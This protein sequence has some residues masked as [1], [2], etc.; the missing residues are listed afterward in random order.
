MKEIYLVIIILI[1][2]ILNIVYFIYDIVKFFKKQYYLNISLDEMN[3]HN[4]SYDVFDKIRKFYTIYIVDKHLI[5]IILFI[6]LLVSIIVY[7]Y[8]RGIQNIINDLT[9]QLNTVVKK[10]PQNIFE[11]LM[12]VTFIK[13]YI[14]LS[15]SIIVYIVYF[16]YTICEVIL[17]NNY[18]NIYEYNKNIQELY[19]YLLTDYIIYATDKNNISKTDIQKIKEWGFSGE[20]DIIKLRTGN[21]EDPDDM[22]LKRLKLLV[23]FVFCEYY[24]F[25]RTNSDM[26]NISNLSK[27]NNLNKENL[28][29]NLPSNKENILPS[30]SEIKKR[31]RDVLTIIKGTDTKYS[32]SSDNIVKLDAKYNEI[33]IKIFE[34]IKNIK[35]Y[36]SSKKIN[37]I[38]IISEFIM[39]II[40]TIFAII[41]VFYIIHLLTKSVSIEIDN[42]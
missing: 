20:E 38:I 36:N 31:F 23:T 5:T 24:I 22:V 3:Y 11:K 4:I 21:I 39:T 7:I 9:P 14:V 35:K 13:I 18:K 15:L 6:L 12:S 29:L 1:V 37:I 42:K 34:D 19:D 40:Y 32:L 33:Y 30:L 25:K 41:L 2:L 28:F 17:L 8:Y 10:I 27:D 26:L 16:I